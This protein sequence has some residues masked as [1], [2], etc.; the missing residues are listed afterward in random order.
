MI[1][2][3]TIQLSAGTDRYRLEA[4]VRFVGVDLLV[5]I[6]GGEVPHIGAVAVAQPRPSLEPPHEKISASTSVICLLGHK[7]DE[8]AKAAA[9]KLAA[10]VNRAVVVSA[11]MHWEQLDPAGIKVVE[12]N[13]RQIVDL[14]LEELRQR[15]HVD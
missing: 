9:E 15:G 10:A 2:D 5:A 3:D 6:Y 13:A 7:E 12:S 1:A 14:I 8:L 11:G 4:S